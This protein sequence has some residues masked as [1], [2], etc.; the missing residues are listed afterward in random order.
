MH[1]WPAKGLRILVYLDDG[2][3]AATG[4]QAAIEASQLVR[5]KRYTKQGLLHTPN[6]VHLAAY[7]APAMAWVHHR[8]GIGANQNTP[9][10]FA[11][12]GNTLSQARRS[13]R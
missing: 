11:L 4:K 5:S 2:L 8:C 10:K 9:E 7:Q 12:L 3:S 13:V 1:Y 6:K